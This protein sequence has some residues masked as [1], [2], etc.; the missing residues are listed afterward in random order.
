MTLLLVSTLLFLV[1]LPLLLGG[2]LLRREPCLVLWG[3]KAVAV[4]AYALLLFYLGNWQMLSYY[5]RYA[6]L[7]IGVAALLV[8]VHRMRDAPAWRRPEGWAWAS[9]LLAA[10]LGAVVIAGL[11]GVVQGRAVPPDPVALQA[12]L[13]GGPY[14]VANGGSDPLLN[15]HMQVAGPRL[16]DWRGQ[17]WGLDVVK[18]Y[19]SGNRARGLAPTALDRYAIF[20]TPVYAPCGG[21]VHAVENDRPDPT[22]PTRDT[23]HKAGNYVLLRCAPD[24]YVLLAHLRQ[25]SVRVAPG[26]T[27]GP[28]TRLGTI[29]NSGNSWEPH[30]HLSAQRGPGGRTP[31]DADPRPVVIEGR[32]LVRN[33]L[34]RAD[35]PRPP[36]A[37]RRS[38]A[39]TP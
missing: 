24:A 9:P 12:P 15:P 22:P 30:L 10:L 14:Y 6:L 39:P 20:G 35:A 5:G 38:A 3:G 16:A 1:G 26:D 17:R 33:D 29:G 19:P 11:V 7:G 8:G 37:H 34:L 31:L 23:T 27:V 36:T 28:G 21:R 2:W 4:S 25:H 13:R 32:F 18:L